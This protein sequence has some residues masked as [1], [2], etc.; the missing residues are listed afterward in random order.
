MKHLF[1]NASHPGQRVYLPTLER[2]IRFSNQY[3]ETNDQAEVDELLWVMERGYID[4]TFT[5]AEERN[6]ELKSKRMKADA[7]ERVEAARHARKHAK[8]AVDA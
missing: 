4:A 8:E 2:E 1:K 5:S 7:T 6:L 3:Y